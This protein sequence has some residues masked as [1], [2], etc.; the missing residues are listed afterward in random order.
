V[1]IISQQFVIHKRTIIS[2]PKESCRVCYP[3]A[4]VVAAVVA[5]A[6]DKETVDRALL[7]RVAAHT[8]VGIAVVEV[9]NTAAAGKKAGRRHNN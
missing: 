7:G 9:R 5:V 1:S 6:V 2:Y 8:A 4:V 3:L